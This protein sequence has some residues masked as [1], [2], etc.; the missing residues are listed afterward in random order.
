MYIFAMLAFCACVCGVIIET[1]ASKGK[2]V[3]YIATLEFTR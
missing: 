3:R 2:P 1:K